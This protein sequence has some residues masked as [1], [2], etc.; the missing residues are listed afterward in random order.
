MTNNIKVNNTSGRFYDVKDKMYIYSGNEINNMSL[1]NTWY[2]SILRTDE[3]K[4][5]N[6]NYKL[7]ATG[8]MD[9]SSGRKYIALPS[10]IDPKDP[11]IKRKYNLM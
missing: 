6:T 2:N 8:D 3:F 11:Y 1:S 10:D 5:N 7:H 9:L 4:P